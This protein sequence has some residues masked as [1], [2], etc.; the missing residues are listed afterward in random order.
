M[1][2]DVMPSPVG[3]LVLTATDEG[4]T[5]VLF[6]SN[7]HASPRLAEWDR[8]GAGDA[9][10]AARSLAAARAQ[11]EEY[12]A[13]TRRVFD[14]PLAPNGTPFQRRVWLALREIPFGA[15]TTYGAIA[16]RLGDPKSVRAIG[17]A[18][19]RNPIPIIVPCH[20]VIGADGSL[21]GFGGGLERKQWLLTHERPAAEQPS[22]FSQ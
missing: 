21:I 3:Q 11:L 14:L 13:G 18:N 6:E 12:F 17:A 1:R 19:G 22:L 15:T 2:Y 10:D 20:R 16:R 7:R 4:L 8:I 5:G 9:D